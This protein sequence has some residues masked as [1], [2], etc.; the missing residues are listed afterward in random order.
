MITRIKKRIYELY[1]TICRQERRAMDAGKTEHAERLHH[2]RL[3]ALAIMK[4]IDEE[5]VDEVLGIISQ[6]KEHE[7]VP[8][9]IAWYLEEELRRSRDA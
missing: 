9:P 7:N 4:I 1:N 2:E 6:E 3:T 5:V 8:G